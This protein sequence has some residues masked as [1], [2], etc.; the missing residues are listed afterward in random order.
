MSRL[1]LKH[2]TDLSQKGHRAHEELTAT[3]LWGSTC[4][5]RLAGRI[6]VKWPKGKDTPIIWFEEGE[7]VKVE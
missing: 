5:S 2:Q 6:T 7:G 1:Y 3:I 4:S